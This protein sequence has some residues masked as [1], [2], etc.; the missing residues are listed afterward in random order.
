MEPLRIKLIAVLLVAVYFIESSHSTIA[1]GVAVNNA[2]IAP[3][4]SA[5][6]DISSISKGLLIPRMTLVERNAITNPATGLIIFQTDNI[7]GIYFYDGS[8]WVASGSGG[9][10]RINDLLDAK[11]GGSSVFLADGAGHMDDGSNNFNV[12]LGYGALF[13]NTSGERNTGIGHSALYHNET[14][15]GNTAVGYNA[16]I[17]N[18]YYNENVAIGAY[19]LNWNSNGNYNVGIGH[20]ANNFNTDGS[21]NTIIGC[22]AGAGTA[23]HAK[24][25]N[26]FIGYQA[27]YY[28]TGDNKLYIENSNSSSPLIYGDFSNDKVTINDVLRLSPRATPPSSPTEG[29]IYVNSSDHHIYCYLNG[30]WVQLD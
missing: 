8:D 6:L 29:E 30:S 14:G 22:H 26:I 17:S 13:K 28:E 7:P 18:G 24:S 9:A 10:L 5:L 2:G 23:L 11:T 16:M 20:S 21:N 15:Q 25:G 27:G 3:H 12:G 1:Q 19:A 4:E